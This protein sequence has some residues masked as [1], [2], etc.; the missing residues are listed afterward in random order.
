MQNIFLSQKNQFQNR[1]NIRFIDRI[2]GKT[3]EEID[4]LL[5]LV[6]IS[7]ERAI[8]RFFKVR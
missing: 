2:V 6:I 5:K 8:Q 4:W 7:V 1:T 3:F